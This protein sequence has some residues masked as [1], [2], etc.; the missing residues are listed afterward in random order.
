MLMTA[1]L[2]PIGPYFKGQ[3][4]GYVEREQQQVRAMLSMRRFHIVQ[5]Q[6]QQE[7]KVC[8][9]IEESLGLSAYCP[10]VP[11]NVR[12]NAHKH[13]KVMRPM[14]TGY[15][16]A[17]FDPHP[18][19]E[20]WQKIVDVRGVIR[21]FKIDLRPV[22]VPHAAMDRIRAKESDLASGRI[23]HIPMV[24]AKVGDIVRLVECGAYTGL[25]APVAQINEQ[26]GRLC[27]TLELFGRPSTY[28]LNPDQIEVV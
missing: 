9:D 27:V 8:R 3:I 4:V 19:G 16:F 22:S 17:G 20:P 1:E 7:F 26:L 5:T 18:D 11:A 24:N 21:L 14:F 23:G 28:W 2:K 12:V 13:R 10:K 25:F 6:S 15:I